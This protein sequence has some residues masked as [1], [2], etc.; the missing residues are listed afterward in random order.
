M[1]VSTQDRRQIETKP[2]DTDLLSVITETIDDQ[3]P[4]YGVINV[5]R[6]AATGVVDIALRILCID[7]VIAEIIDTTK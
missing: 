7:A 2:V 5:E 6:V 3:P 4:Y 1:R